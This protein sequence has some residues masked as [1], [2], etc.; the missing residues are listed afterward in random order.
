MKRNK[1]TKD[2]VRFYKKD[3]DNDLGRVYIEDKVSGSALRP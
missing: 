2:K 3:V 1:W